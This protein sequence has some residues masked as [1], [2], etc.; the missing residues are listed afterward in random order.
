MASSNIDADTEALIAQLM[1]EDF[2]ESYQ[3]HC[4]PIGASYHDY[5]EPLSSYER[6]C[7]D[8]ENDPDDI[9]EGSG[10]GPDSI[11]GVN[12]AAA[13]DE[14]LDS[15]G[16]PGEDNWDSRFVDEDGQVQDHT[17]PEQSPQAVNEDNTHS[18]SVS[19]SNPT[20]EDLTVSPAPATSPPTDNVTTNPVA[21][22]PIISAST[23]QPTQPTT[24]ICTE[25][26]RIPCNH[27]SPSDQHEPSI[28]SSHLK[29]PNEPLPPSRGRDV[30]S[31][32]DDGLDYSS[33]KG[34]GKAVRAYDEFKRGL[35][36]AER[37]SRDPKFAQRNR[38]RRNAEY[39]GEDEEQEED[40]DDEDDDYDEE[41]EEGEIR[42]ED[43]PFVRIPWPCAEK[44]ELLA[45]REDAAVVEIRV[46]DEETLES[47]LRDIERRD[48]ERRRKGEVLV[49]DR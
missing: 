13:P 12:E 32:W 45:R 35:R 7:L 39:E 24:E 5:E 16:P 28:P 6:Q 27:P 1:A 38:E 8:A 47:I 11:D 48:D 19:C 9:G 2:G 37:E 31:Q 42:D 41:E 44:D 20:S 4:A 49:G 25:P 36:D 22:T 29:Q 26:I 46:G 3:A 40:D 23:T 10:W 43:L 14:G 18:D 30:E 15:T 17:A 33:S 34:K 21:E